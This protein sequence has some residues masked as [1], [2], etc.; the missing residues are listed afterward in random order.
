VLS[1]RK[2]RTAAVVAASFALAA[3][4]SAQAATTRPCGSVF[5]TV[6]GSKSGGRF[7]AL[8]V[9]CARARVVMR[10]ALAHQGEFGIGAPAGWKCVRGGAPEFSRVA[11]ECTRRTDRARVRL[12]RR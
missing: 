6:A 12:F 5:V 2:V 4:A 3:P 11:I 8:R 1:R 7:D 10:Y 9:S